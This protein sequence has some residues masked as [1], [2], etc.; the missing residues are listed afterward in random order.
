MKKQFLFLSAIMI[1]FAVFMANCEKPQMNEDV[2]RDTT[3]AGASERSTGVTIS[4]ADN[5]RIC[6]QNMG[7]TTCQI[8]N[9]GNGTLSRPGSVFNLIADP[10]PA[11]YMI[12]NGANN[13]TITVTV[14]GGQVI[15]VNI[16]AFERIRVDIDAANVATF[17]AC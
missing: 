8:C 3:G 10:T 13:N 16:G 15:S 1:L 6:G 17:V 9:A 14:A 11:S 12:I 5:F 4:G 2:I 7:T